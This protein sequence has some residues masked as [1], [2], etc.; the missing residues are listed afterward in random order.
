M[1]HGDGF[2]D[3][4]R[5]ILPVLAFGR[6]GILL[7]S[8]SQTTQLGTFTTS[9]AAVIHYGYLWENKLKQEWIYVSI[10]NFQNLKDSVTSRVQLRSFGDGT[11]NVNAW[12]HT[13]LHVPLRHSVFFFLSR[14]PLTIR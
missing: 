6:H 13:G 9:F 14:L 4:V 7:R 11:V 8:E 1:P 5:H 12:F 10:N 2:A 3:I